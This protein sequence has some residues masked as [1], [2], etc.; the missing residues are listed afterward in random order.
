MGVTWYFQRLYVPS[1]WQGDRV[2][3]R[4]GSANYAARCVDQREA[5]R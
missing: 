4:V 5:C 1:S 2:Y 3:L